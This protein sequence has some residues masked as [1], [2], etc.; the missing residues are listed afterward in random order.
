MASNCKIPN[1]KEKDILKKLAQSIVNGN[2]IKGGDKRKRNDEVEESEQGT[3]TEHISPTPTSKSISQT[4]VRE[5]IE[6]VHDLT[7]VE[8]HVIKDVILN[9]MQSVTCIPPVF[10]EYLIKTLINKIKTTKVDIHKL[11]V[12]TVAS[13]TIMGGIVTD[14]ENSVYY[15]EIKEKVLE[16]L[17]HH[18][19][20]AMI[21]ISNVE[22]L[23]KDLKN[24]EEEL[25][26]K[27]GKK[28]KVDSP[29]KNTGG[30]S[31]RKHRKSNKKRRTYKR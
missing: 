3:Q 29:N 15:L 16:K 31:I 10:W 24:T 21:K 4:R 18:K 17:L 12:D 27:K 8:P 28:R 6:A 7:T 2:G 20:E 9:Y 19:V 30:K 13:I 25:L 22:E 26:E 11:I 23:K 1:N 5:T 14:I